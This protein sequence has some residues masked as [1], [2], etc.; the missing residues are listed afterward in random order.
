[1]MGDACSAP[2]PV[3]APASASSFGLPQAIAAAATANKEHD[4]SQTDAF[5]IASC[6]KLRILRLIDSAFL[7]LPRKREREQEPFDH[8]N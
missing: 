7:P 5:I 6:D 1:M 3:F 8:A 4:S 2:A